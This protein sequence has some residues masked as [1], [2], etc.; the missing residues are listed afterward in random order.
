MHAGS[1]YCPVT[2]APICGWAVLETNDDLRE[3]VMAW[4]VRQG[5]SKEALGRAVNLMHPRPATA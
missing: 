3:L 4:A 5:V 2:G 1:A